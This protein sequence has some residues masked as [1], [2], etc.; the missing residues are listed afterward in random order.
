MCKGIKGV[1]EVVNVQDEGRTIKLNDGHQ[2]RAD[3]GMGEWPVAVEC[4]EG[5]GWR[6][7]NLWH[8]GPKACGECRKKAV[9]GLLS[10]ASEGASVTSGG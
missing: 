4:R 3:C 9:V 8:A 7:V 6:E 5:G 10:L 1:S 2:K